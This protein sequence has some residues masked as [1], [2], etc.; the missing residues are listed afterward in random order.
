MRRTTCTALAIAI[1]A[2]GAAQAI[3]LDTHAMASDVWGSQYRS[4]HKITFTG[5]VTG[6][7]RTRPVTSSDNEVTLLVR[8]RDGGGSSVVDVGP[9]WYVDHQVAKIRLKDNVQVTGSKILI[10]RHGIVLAEQ[11]RI[12]GEG[13]L[14]VS[15][16]RASGRAFWMGTETNSVV[17]V[18]TGP[19]VLTGTFTN[20]GTYMLNDVPYVQGVLQTANG[21]LNVDLGPQWYYGQQNLDYRVGDGVSIVAGPN[22][23]T[24]GPNLNIYPSYSIY[25]GP[26]VYSIRNENGVPLY[27]WGQQ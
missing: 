5:R 20:F 27:Y 7:V 3:K 21:P 2:I 25:R 8:N 16:R 14:V 12:N 24:V 22:P 19:N 15:L 6:I 18:P 23:F 11:I 26:Q 10:G 1:C 4:G 9:A 17:S 13:G